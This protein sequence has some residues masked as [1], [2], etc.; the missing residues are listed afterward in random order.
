MLRGVLD[1]PVVGGI[2]EAAESQGG[3][4]VVALGRV[5][6]DDVHD[7]FDVRLMEG[8]YHGLE[9]VDLPSEP[10]GGGVAVVGG[11]EADGVVSPIV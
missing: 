4:H 3:P 1:E 9:L 10:V 8:L 5:I 6:V 2:V 7:D 11:E